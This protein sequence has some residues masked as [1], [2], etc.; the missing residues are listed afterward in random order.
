MLVG[1]QFD[2]VGLSLYLKGSEIGTP[3]FTK[4]ISTQLF[5]NHIFFDDILVGKTYFPPKN[6]CFRLL[7]AVGKDSLC[8]IAL[9]LYLL[10]S[11]SLPLSLSV[12]SY[13]W[14]SAFAYE[15]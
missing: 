10:I 13:S 9:Q 1:Y 2:T 5:P 3:L 14:N 7:F 12:E 8:C 4:N 6:L 11:F 15:T